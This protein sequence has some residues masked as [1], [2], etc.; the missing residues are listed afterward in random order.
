M[1]EAAAG[2]GERLDIRH[3]RKKLER[4]LG[5]FHAG[6]KQNFFVILAQFVD[7]YF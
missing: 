4:L 2:V 7:F 1:E 5:L 6:C 3:L